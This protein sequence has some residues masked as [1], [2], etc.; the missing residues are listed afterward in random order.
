[1]YSPGEASK[2]KLLPIV[3]T[4]YQL[5]PVVR[6]IVRVVKRGATHPRILLGVAFDAAFFGIRMF[7]LS[8][9]DVSLVWPLTSLGFVITAFA[10]VLPPLA[11]QPHASGGGVPDRPRGGVGVVERSPEAIHARRSGRFRRGRPHLW[12][13]VNPLA[14]PRTVRTP[15]PMPRWWMRQCITSAVAGPIPSTSTS[16]GMLAAKTSPMLPNRSSSCSA[17]RGPIPVVPFPIIDF[18][19]PDLSSGRGG[20]G[21]GAINVPRTSPV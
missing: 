5:V 17:R 4:S 13:A 18:D 8:R 20:I 1:M 11:R 10:A 7:L 16:A 3:V 14:H 15:V 6:E 9:A 2:T 19:L 21:C 12:R